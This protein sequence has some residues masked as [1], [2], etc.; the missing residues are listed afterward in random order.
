M[1]KT[2][3]FSQEKLFNLKGLF[4]Q[5]ECFSGDLIVQ[6][7]EGPKQM[8][9]LKIGDEVMSMDETTVRSKAGKWRVIFFRVLSD[10]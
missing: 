6:T 5:T 7:V 4:I 10:R 8:S 2:T 9:E 1:T 3:L